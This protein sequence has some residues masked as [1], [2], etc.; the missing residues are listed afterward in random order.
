MREWLRSRSRV[1][2]YVGIGLVAFVVLWN[3]G[4]ADI[5]LL[6]G[7]LLGIVLIVVS[8]LGGHD[9]AS[10]PEAAVGTSEGGI[11]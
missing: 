3:V 5:T 4:G 11:G 10:D 6:A 7:A 2:G 1:I 9:G 8:L